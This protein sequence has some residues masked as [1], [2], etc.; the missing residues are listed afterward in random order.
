MYHHGLTVSAQIFFTSIA[1]TSDPQAVRKVSGIAARVS[2]GRFE[3]LVIG[4]TFSA[5]TS[6][7]S[8]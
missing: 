4:I 7:Y 2:Q 1:S 6:I 8:A 3:V 5:G